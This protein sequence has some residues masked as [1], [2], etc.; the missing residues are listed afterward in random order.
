MEYRNKVISYMLQ[1]I[2]CGHNLTLTEYEF[3]VLK[4]EVLW[5]V[6]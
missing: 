1:I 3:K 6:F 2:L 5:K 4:N